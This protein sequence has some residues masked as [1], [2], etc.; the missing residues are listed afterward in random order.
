MKKGAREES[1]ENRKWCVENREWRKA[2]KEYSMKHGEYKWC[3][4]SNKWRKEN[5]K[6]MKGKS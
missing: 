6:C 3:M 2:I 4:E 1:M 5:G